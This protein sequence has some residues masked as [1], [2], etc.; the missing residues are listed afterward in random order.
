[1][2]IITRVEISNCHWNKILF[3]HFFLVTWQVF[4]AVYWTLNKIK[5]LTLQNSA[6]NKF[7]L[8]CKDLMSLIRLYNY[9]I[10]KNYK[11][12][13]CLNDDCSE[14]FFNQQICWWLT[15]VVDCSRLTINMR[16]SII[17]KIIRFQDQWWSLRTFLSHIIFNIHSLILKHHTPQCWMII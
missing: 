4:H 3:L 1:M 9:V 12:K 17:F 16:I 5:L 2:E 11:F 15:I 14:I 13:L 10:L 7:E 8:I 6:I